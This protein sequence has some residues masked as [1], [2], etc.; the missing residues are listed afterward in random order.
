M[1]TGSTRIRVVPGSAGRWE[2]R[3]PGS[4]WALLEVDSPT[5]A[6]QR[7]RR[8]LSRGGTVEVLDQTGRV[9]ETQVVPPPSATNPWWYMRPKK[10]WWVVGVLF[11]VQGV[12]RFAADGFGWLGVLLPLTGAFYLSCLTAS[13]RRDNRIVGDTRETG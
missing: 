10:S 5:E 12:S 11:L 4:T 2:V 6:V 7:A 13:H 8:M 1:E 3:E 9:L